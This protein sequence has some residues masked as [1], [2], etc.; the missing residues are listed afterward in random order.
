MAIDWWDVGTQVGDWWLG[1]QSAEN[2]QDNLLQGV[3][4]AR[5]DIKEYAQPYQDLAQWG[6]E[7]YKQEGPFDFTYEGYLSSPEFQ[8]Q[9]DQTRQALERGAAAG[10]TGL[11]SGQTLADL[12]DRLHNVTAQEYDAEF[13]RQLLGQDAREGYW[14]K[15]IQTGATL[16]GD[17]GQALADLSLARQGIRAQTEAKQDD[18]LTDLI[19]NLL[20]GGDAGSITNS[21]KSVYEALGGEA[22]G[23]D[24]MDVASE[25]FDMGM[26]GDLATMGGDAAAAAWGAATG[27]G[28]MDALGG[29]TPEAWMEGGWTSPFAG[30]NQLK[31]LGAAVASG[32]VAGWSSV[33]GMSSD[34][35]MNEA[36]FI[37]DL[38]SEG[39]MA[40]TEGMAAAGANAG[41]GSS[42]MNFLSSPGGM[43]I[44][45]AA[46]TLL[47]GGDAKD[48]A[49][50]GGASYLGATIGSAILPGIGTAI[51]GALGGMIASFGF[52]DKTAKA[53]SAMYLSSSTEGFKNGIYSE[54]AF[55]NIGFKGGATRHL[56]NINKYYKPAFDTIANVD[57]M[58]ASALTPEELQAVKDSIGEGYRY[59][60]ERNEGKISPKK[61]MASTFK[62]RAAMLK[63]VLGEERFNELQLGDLY[64]SMVD[65]IFPKKATKRS[66]KRARRGGY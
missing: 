63:N 39:T 49:I 18:Q 22:S 30:P 62:D 16:A 66:R 54:G 61:V 48:A 59:R 3:S 9:Q 23:M 21:V 38:T 12:Q 6:M 36:G 44:T 56:N 27:Q 14:Y 26:L 46:M 2:T 7:G 32:S 45:A 58:V 52:G 1:N 25:L 11:Y 50:A 40:A 65:Q 24:V 37:V 10:P 15:P 34:F 8:W 60:K 51:G 19:S 42:I 43:G 53:D 29:M 33:P 4:K 35:V 17:T 41:M 64:Q 20:P 57:N 13:K 47:T 31:D 5:G 28:A 55:G